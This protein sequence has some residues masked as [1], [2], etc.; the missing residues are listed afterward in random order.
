[1]QR[2]TRRMGGHP[3]ASGAASKSICWRLFRRQP[4]RADLAEPETVA[5]TV[6]FLLNTARY[7]VHR[8]THRQYPPRTHHVV[9]SRYGPE[10]TTGEQDETERDKVAIITG[11]ARRNWTRHGAPVRQGRRQ[12]RD[13][14]YPA[15]NWPPTPSLKSKAGGT[16][17][18]PRYRRLE[19]KVNQLDT[20]VAKTMERFQPD[21]HPVC[22]N[23]GVICKYQDVFSGRT[24]RRVGTPS[25]TPS[26]GLLRFQ[27]VARDDRCGNTGVIL[28]TASVGAVS[29]SSGMPPM[30]SPRQGCASW[31]CHFIVHFIST[32]SGS[33]AIAPGTI[34]TQFGAAGVDPRSA[35][36]ARWRNGR[37]RSYR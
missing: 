36:K 37:R 27:K 6:L 28:N 22:N 2:V 18:S 33:N 32:I 21:R 7:R 24:P 4:D 30:T 5:E 34:N 11:G 31:R 23:A 13:R 3:S 25:W 1:M 35:R 8:P 17:G 26:V 12:G 15:P 9:P 14:R 10:P 16:A 20:M 19:R 29:S